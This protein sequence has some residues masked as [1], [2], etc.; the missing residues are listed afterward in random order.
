MRLHVLSA[1]GFAVAASLKNRVLNWARKLRQPRYLVGSL[2]AAAYFW[3]LFWNPLRQSTSVAAMNQRPGGLGAQGMALIL[4]FMQILGAWI[5]GPFGQ[6]I[7]FAENEVLLLFPAP[8]R[9]RELLLY[10]WMKE[11]PP[12]LL[13]AG[14]FAFILKRLGAPS[15]GTTFVTLFLMNN[16]LGAHGTAARLV[17][18]WIRNRGFF[19]RLLLPIPALTFLGI[20]VWAGMEAFGDLRTVNPRISPTAQLVDTRAFETA[21]RPLV[22]LTSPISRPDFRS[23]LPTLGILLLLMV[24]M[25]R[26]VGAL[27]IAF[28]E[29]ST[30]LAAKLA[31]IKSGG[32]QAIQ[33]PQKLVVKPTSKPI[34]DLGP[35]GPPWTAFVWK[36]LISIGRMKRMVIFVLPTIFITA[37]VLMSLRRKHGTEMA[38]VVSFMIAMILPYTALAGPAMLRI[39]L[40]LDL[41][42]FDVLKAMPIRARQ[43]ILGEVLATTFVLWAIQLVLLTIAV[44]LAPKLG[45][46]EKSLTIMGAIIIGFGAF[47]G[48]LDFAIATGQNLLALFFPS[49][50]RLGNAPRAGFDAFGQQLIGALMSFFGFL[51]LLILPG[52]LAAGAGFLGWYFWRHSGALI[53]GGLMAGLALALEAWVLICASE[54]RYDTFD[55]SQETMA[56]D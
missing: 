36:N 7:V 17:C 41:L 56:A 1:F 20:A 37:F 35:I 29:Q 48:G 45:D 23:A 50:I 12:N 28:E 40:R 13:F 26:L 5:S 9:R 24:S 42:H 32:M 55:L 25:R 3:W 21:F 34:F 11:T 6:G 4:A 39:D 33:E 46:V 43:L 31:R 2:L 10:R 38:T 52:L 15:L 30:V 49:F 53:C 27:D 47:L 54:R 22:W 16:I 18:L 14:I 8:L 19:W 51:I 44:V